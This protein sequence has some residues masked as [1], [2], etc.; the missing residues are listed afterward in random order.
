MPSIILRLRIYLIRFITSIYFYLDRHHSTP[1][2]PSSSFRIKIPT[3]DNKSKLKLYFY[4]PPSYTRH[5]AS[6]SAAPTSTKQKYSTIINFHGGGWT[7]GT[8][9]KDARFA[10]EVT[11]AGYLFISASYRL[12]PEHAHPTQL[13]DCTAAVLYL[14]SRFEALRIDKEHIVLCG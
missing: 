4:T 5:S 10:A 14:V 1:L 9:K 7:Y 6:K 8:P 12:F 3:T 2:P 13:N 11:K